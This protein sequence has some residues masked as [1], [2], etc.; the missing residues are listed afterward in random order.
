MKM[1]DSPIR[2]LVRGAYD[3]Q[4]LRISTGNR[5]VANF[6]AKLGQAPGESAVDALDDEAK[7]LLFDL[8]QRHR[9][10]T[11]AMIEA[12]HKGPF[13]GDE[14][15]STFTELALV[16]SYVDLE[17]NE[18]EQFKRLQKVLDEIPIYTQFLSGI[19]G[20][21]PAMA[22]VI[23]SEFDITKAKYPSSLWAYAG[24]DVGGDGLGRS[25]R[26]EH[27]VKR[28]YISRDGEV[29]ERVGITYNPWL[30]TKLMGVL[31]ASFL[32]SKS[33]YAEIYAQYRHRIET[34]PKRTIR[35]KAGRS[36]DEWT[37]MRRH[38][39]ALRYMIKMFLID[40][41]KAWRAIEGLPVAPS[42]HEAKMGH[43]HAA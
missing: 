27:L 25:K 43:K 34:D 21:G 20:I 4:K 2:T 12:K 40:L 23:I 28:E 18:T 16:A 9:R 15:I 37:K 5:T 42:Y 6:R 24:L 38:Q 10:I 1:T 22:G 14:L 11:D 26:A 17:R 29:K 32:R 31:A 8:K 13:P 3:L 19:R 41:Y 39:A 36:D 7:K 30:K 33:P 35:D